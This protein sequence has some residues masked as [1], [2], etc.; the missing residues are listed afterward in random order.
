MQKSAHNIHLT[1]AQLN[2]FPANTLQQQQ[3]YTFV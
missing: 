1:A 3:L 2:L